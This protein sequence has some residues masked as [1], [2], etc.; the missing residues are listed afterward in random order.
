[1][2]DNEI[3]ALLTQVLPDL[4]EAEWA[5]LVKK[6]YVD[7][8]REDLSRDVPD[9]LNRLAD[10]IR[11]LPGRDSPPDAPSMV[12]PSPRPLE[13]ER[14]ATRARVDALSVLLAKEAEQEPA[15]QAF[16]RLYLAEGFLP[17]EAVQ[18]WIEAQ[19][20]ADGPP[21]RWLAAPPPIPEGTRI[22]WDGIVMTL[23][24]P[25]TLPRLDPRAGATAG[26]QRAYLTYGVPESA[27]ERVVLVRNGGVLDQLRRLSEDLARQYDWQ[28]PQA[29]LF[30]LTGRVPLV[31]ALRVRTGW[32]FP[33][34]ATVRITL[35]VHPS[36]TPQEVAEAYRKVRREMIPGRARPLTEKHARLAAF[37]ARRPEGETWADRMAAWNREYPRWRYK[38]SS[39]FS[40]DALRA[41]RR[42]L[43]P[44]YAAGD[45]AKRADAGV[46]VDGEQEASDDGD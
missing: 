11:G 46:E 19:S 23:D 24:P 32:H 31:P 26:T 30:V 5:W 28:P 6:R 2:H 16:R 37:T 29:T 13:R 39:N 44:S 10:E 17:P 27:W 18:S 21:S 33:L 22:D 45:W 25:L 15:V 34:T 8:C 12:D 43:Q 14:R 40:R 36:V 1:M 9:A 35:A 7:D 41:Q 38:Q 3:R 20:A 42:L 4:T